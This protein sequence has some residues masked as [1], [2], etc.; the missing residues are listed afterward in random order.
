[1]RPIAWEQVRALVS[2][3][4]VLFAAHGFNVNLEYGARSLGQL[5]PHLGLSSAD[6]FFGV[7]WPGDWWLPAV[8]YPFEGDVSMDCGRRLADACKRWMSN[9][10]SFSFIS[11]SLGA[12][13]VLEAIRHLD[14]SAKSVCL[15][16]AAIN[17]DC[18]LTEYAPAAANAST[19]SVLASHADLV[20]KVAYQIGDPFSDLLH[21]DHAAFQLALGYDGPP[22]PAAPPIEGASQIPDAAAYGHGDYLPPG[23]SIQSLEEAQNAKWLLV[24]EFMRRTYRGLPQTWPATIG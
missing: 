7:L 24:S 10:Q 19:I 1:M 22:R 18:L 5:E 9:A 6:I 4:N 11:H 17:R 2:G 15:T 16:A 13:L 23:D 3:R 12:R 20:L 14:R 21:A 8:N